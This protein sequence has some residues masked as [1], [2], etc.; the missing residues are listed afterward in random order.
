MV[1]PLLQGNLRAG[2]E[3]GAEAPLRKFRYVTTVQAT[4]SS[5][6]AGATPSAWHTSRVS[7]GRFSV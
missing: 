4:F 7:C 3:K 2:S 5:N 1:L 6:A